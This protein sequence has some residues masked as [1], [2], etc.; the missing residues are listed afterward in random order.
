MT[1][2]SFLHHPFW[3]STTARRGNPLEGSFF[4]PGE[5]LFHDVAVGWLDNYIATASR[6]TLRLAPAAMLENVAPTSGPRLLARTC[7]QWL[8]RSPSRS[9]SFCTRCLKARHRPST[10]KVSLISWTTPFRRVA[11]SSGVTWT[12]PRVTPAEGTRQPPSK[13]LQHSG[14]P[15]RPPLGSRPLVLAVEAVASVIPSC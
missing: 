7:T 11:N 13:Y 2:P 10:F 1:P 8:I 3:Q 15:H 14:R 9:T 6:S 12:P 4:S 5:I